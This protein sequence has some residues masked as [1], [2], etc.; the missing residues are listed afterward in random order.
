MII[1]FF[2]FS[3]LGLSGV[4]ADYNFDRQADSLGEESLWEDFYGDDRQRKNSPQKTAINH[5][6][7]LNRDQRVAFDRVSQSIL[8]KGDNHLFFI[9]GA[10]GCGIYLL[11]FRY[12]LYGYI[13]GKTHLYNTLIRWCLAGK[14][15]LDTEETEQGRA[16]YK[17]FTPYILIISHT[18]T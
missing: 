2:Y 3:E 11:F 10:G 16:V 13:T 17:F 6:R 9:E 4:P 15:A 14:P 12:L 1:F 8:G 7:K 18:D 5:V